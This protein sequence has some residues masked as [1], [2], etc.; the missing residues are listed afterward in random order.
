VATDGGICRFNPSGS[1]RFVV[2]RPGESAD[3]LRVNTLREDRNGFIWA[4]TYDGLY[5]V[6]PGHDVPRFQ[7]I[8]IGAPADY[9]ESSLVNAIL[10]DRLNT[11]WI[12][13]RSGIY[14]RPDGGIWTRYFTRHGLPENFIGMLLQDSDGRIWA[15]TRTRGFCRLVPEPAGDGPIVSRCYSTKNGLPDNDVRF[16]FQSSD[17]KLWVATAG[18]LSE[19]LPAAPPG[20]Q[21]RNY[22]PANGLSEAVIYT[23][24]E[25]GY[26]NL[27]IGT[28]LA[29]IMK[30]V[31]SGI[32]TYGESD[33]YR[34][35]VFSSGIFETHFGELVV[36]AGTKEHT[37]INRFDGKRFIATEVKLPHNVDSPWSPLFVQDQSDEWWVARGP[38]L[39]RFP[40]IKRV[41]DLAF[42][43]PKAV[44]GTKD[45]IVG[46]SVHPLYED[47]N[48]D[49]WFGSYQGYRC[50]VY[51]WERSTET[52]HS[53]ADAVN[54]SVL[55]T[56]LAT[57]FCQDQGD[58]LWIGFK[59]G[60][61]VRGRLSTGKF[62]L[63]E[64]APKT[65]IH[66]LH[67]D[68]A[69]HLWIGSLN[70]LSRIDD[71]ASEQPKF[72]TY[73]MADGL[74]SNEI[75]C[76]TDDRRGHVYVGTDSGI[77][78]LDSSTDHIS[79]YGI[80]DGLAKGGV[81]AAF[82]DRQG[83]LW[84]ATT[85]G[86]SRLVVSSVAPRSLPPS[87]LI[88]GVRVDDTK[89][90][91]SELGETRIENLKLAPSQHH[92]EVDFLGLHFGAASRLQYQYKLE[93]ADNS[94]SEPTEQR[95]VNY[96]RLSPGAYRFLVRAI[97]T[98]GS[99]SPQP[100]MIEL[101]VI[102]PLWRRCWFIA[103]AAMLSAILVYA[104]HYYRVAH[105]L[106]LENVRTRIATD[107]HDD[108]GSS[109]TQIGLLSELARLHGD[110]DTLSEIAGISRQLAGAV[111]DIVW[112][113]NPRND[114]MSS[115][116]RRIRRFAT[117]LL[118]GSGVE[119]H[120][121][122]PQEDQ[123]ARTGLEVRRQTFL[124][125][126]EAVHNVARHARASRVEIE[127]EITKDVLQLSIKD[128]GTGF[129]SGA[130]QDGNGIFNMKQRASQIRASLAV[131]S[132]PG[133]GTSVTLRAR[134]R[135]LSLLR[136]T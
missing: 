81:D 107:L 73:T 18:G 79:H 55:K 5:R 27:W 29:G 12:A 46:M 71:P 119:L 34:A 14:R 126:K 25:D 28:R 50:D 53:Y 86:I 62:A 15:T 20:E 49:I 93:G 70:G 129:E 125:F 42:A 32:V 6:E 99:I 134:F 59:E 72:R 45:G 47:K 100:A 38:G 135:S 54:S 109:L 75:R 17:R 130:L 36:T 57:A 13:S 41:K 3:S 110:S 122:L 60:G 102:P 22:T 111:S 30:M 65:L 128:N 8:D 21:F 74:S 113:M 114:Y 52:L 68:P 4:G 63:V 78:R 40:K 84:F 95:R 90:P 9:H 51:R 94:W 108:I 85:V 121:R 83:D 76:I 96:A 116:S 103:L 67:A 105:L 43:R 48:G 1:R 127:L 118:G 97:G 23:L 69:N 133:L 136:G 11:M 58:Q 16:V 92:L 44:Y 31:N 104:L 66:A 115:L 7:R 19:F 106:A 77:D 123:E 132:A 56:R 37:W 124:I 88:S 120:F 61:L 2:Y 117:D 80:S 87:I 39:I 112:A 35:V 64:G 91:T 10:F 26:G 33:G 98:G 24:A 131:V 82:C 89:L 101:V